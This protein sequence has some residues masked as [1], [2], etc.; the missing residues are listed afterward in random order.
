MQRE[1]ACDDWIANSGLSPADHAAAPSPSQAAGIRPAGLMLTS[2]ATE[3][4]TESSP[5]IAV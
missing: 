3:I 4:P 5:S 2:G 1:T